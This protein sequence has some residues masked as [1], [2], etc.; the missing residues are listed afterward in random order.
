MRLRMEEQQKLAE[1]KLRQQEQQLAEMQQLL[2]E[3]QK[4]EDK[5]QHELQE[6]ERELSQQLL[7]QKVQWLC[8]TT[9][10]MH[11]V[12]A[13]VQLRSLQHS[14]NPDVNCW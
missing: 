8:V 7:R 10:T 2:L 5:L 4:A 13:K 3:K 1:E 12:V 11:A 14:I 9:W 6:K